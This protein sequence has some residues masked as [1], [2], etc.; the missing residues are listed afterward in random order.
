M[1]IEF[2]NNSVAEHCNDFIRGVG[3]LKEHSVSQALDCFQRAY[4]G[5]HYSDIYHNKYASYCG[6]TRVLNGD[7]AGVEL[8]RDAARQEMIDGDVF[9]NLAYVEWHMNSR[10]RSIGVLEKGLKVDQKHPG[11]NRFQ[12][13]LGTRAKPVIFFFSR[14]NILNKTLGKLVRK[15]VPKTNWTFQHLL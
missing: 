11:L 5:V 4:D 6:L 13:H 1:T 8:C 14:D 9:L 7:R 10:R 12:K 2:K 15:K 3:L